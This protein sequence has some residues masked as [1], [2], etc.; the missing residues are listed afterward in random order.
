MRTILRRPDFLLLFSGL[1]A[2]RIAESVML[3]ALA[4]WVKD[5]TGSN[6]MAGATIFAMAAPMLVAPVIG[7]LVDRFRRRPFFIVANLLTALFLTP[8]YAVRDRSDVWIIYLVGILYG[9][10]YIALGGAVNGLLKQIVPGELLAEANGAVQTVKQGLRLVGPLA[11]AALYAAVGGWPLATVGVLGFTTA[12]LAAA[13]MRVRES[14]P[15]PAGLRWATEVSAGVRHLVGEPALRRVALGAGLAVLV[16]GFTEALIFA[17]VDQ[18]LGQPPAFVGVLVTVQGVGGLVGGLVSAA[19]VRRLGEIG[20]LATAIAAFAPAALALAHPDLRLGFAAM[21]CAGFG[22]PIIFVSLH[23][24][25]QRRTPARLLGRV[26]AASDAL[27]SG[28]QAVSIGAGAVLV[29]VVDYRL[30]FVAM[31]VVT[32]AAAGYLWRGRR[33]SPP[34]PPGPPPITSG[35][36]VR[37]PAP[38]RPLDP[39]PAAVEAPPVSPGRVPPGAA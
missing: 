8:L 1:V 38:R 6:A 16:M 19:V 39:V 17:Y 28:P 31:G 14:A 7:W 12:A 37:V 29:G 33:L 2:S 5:L 26:V 32:L 25:I 4:I 9:V 22:L 23:T 27:I 18:G 21:I 15:E 35:P 36:A 20:A 10:A 13:A 3:L 24:L 30:L 11:G 34:T